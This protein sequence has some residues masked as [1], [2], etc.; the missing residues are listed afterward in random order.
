MAAT[1][2]R[3][4]LPVARRESIQKNLLRHT[5]R[6]MAPLESKT[7]I[8]LKNKLSRCLIAVQ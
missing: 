3:R 6:K 1:K 7:F 8:T 4:Y 2:C 5:V